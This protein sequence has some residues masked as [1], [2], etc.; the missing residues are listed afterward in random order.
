MDNYSTT[1]PLKTRIDLHD[2]FS[3]NTLGWHNWVQNRLNLT[4]VSSVLELGCGTGR[5]WSE[6]DK[7]LLN[8]LSITLTD[9][10]SAM[11]SAVENQYRH[12]Y[13]FSFQHLDLN[14]DFTL[15]C[16]P[17]LLICN[18]VLYHVDDPCQVLEKIR[19]NISSHTT[20]VFATNGMSGMS[21]LSLFLPKRFGAHPFGELLSTFTLQSGYGLVD[22]VFGQAHVYRYADGLQVDAVDPL[23][24]YIL[25]LNWDLSDWEIKESRSLMKKHLD[26][27]GAIYIS[28]D[29]GIICSREL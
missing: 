12:Y 25:S 22:K 14:T 17:D 3:V 11:L 21:E 5:L 29:T 6:V 28:K 8:K 26:E 18:H 20:C 23:M 1:L 4:E 7:T 27:Y 16:Q 2:S 13:N 10:S 19:N 9:N 15:P 24:D